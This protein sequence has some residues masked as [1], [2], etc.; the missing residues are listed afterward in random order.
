M[1]VSVDSTDESKKSISC[2]CY[3]SVQHQFLVYVDLGLETDESY[4][5]EIGASSAQLHVRGD[6]SNKSLVVSVM[7]L[8]CDGLYRHLQSMVLFMV[9]RRSVNWFSITLVQTLTR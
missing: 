9:W 6:L 1:T 3:E 8:Y 2:C 5:L 7:V 4:T